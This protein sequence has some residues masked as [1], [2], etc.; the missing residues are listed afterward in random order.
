MHIARH[1]DGII[2]QRPRAR[3]QIGLTI[4]RLDV[5]DQ[6]VVASD[7]TEILSVRLDSVKTVIRLRD[8]DGDHLAL[9]ARQAGWTEHQRHIKLH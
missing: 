4:V 1:R 6:L 7:L 2:K 9:R 5:L 8:D 3:I